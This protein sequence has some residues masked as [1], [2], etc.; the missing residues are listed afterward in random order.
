MTKQP[1]VAPTV[2]RVSQASANPERLGR[3]P[4]VEQIEGVPVADL[5]AAHGSPLFV[6]SERVLREKIREARAAFEAVYPDTVFAWSYKTNYLDA[7]CRV[8]HSEGSLAEVVSGFEYEKARANGVPGHRIIF[9]GPYKT[10][11]ELR[12]AVAEGA[13]IQVD[14]R[15]EVVALAKL[16]EE[17]GET[18]R[19]GV[20]VHVD[21]GTHAVWSKFGFCA[22]S[23]EALHMIR[24]MTQHTR[25]R[26]RGL[27]CHAGTFLLDATAYATVARSLTELAAAMA[28]AGCGTVDYLN[29]GGGFASRARLH[30]QYLPPEVATPSFDDYAREIAG[31]IR[32]NWP[33]DCPL[34]RLYLETGRALVDEAGWLLGTV[35]AVK[36]R[37]L[38]NG[39]AAA[40]AAYGK[41]GVLAAYGKGGLPA[42]AAGL[43]DR[44]NAV[45]LDA[46][47]GVLYTT[48]WYQPSIHAAAPPRGAVQPTTVYGC[49]CMNIDVIREEAPLPEL[50]AGDAVVMHPVG[51]YNITQSMQ[52]ISYRPAVVMIGLDGAVHVIRR[53][54]ELGDVTGPEITPAYLQHDGDAAAGGRP[55]SV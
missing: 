11:A 36:Q 49:L 17:S 29:L 7:V 23:G 35:V 2:R 13:L 10:P 47:I 51:A 20:R 1:Y 14:N 24:W 45:V 8:F 41:G 6:F 4:V 12:R 48:A 9:N 53:R 31:T 27:H 3:P 33:E 55:D 32:Q 28:E 37:A 30:G 5:L 46:G 44:R 50:R 38:G 43:A 21:T 15:D 26:V 22:A 25:L 16:A 52:F 40:M 19:V 42:V 39:A 34:P 18:I 54:E